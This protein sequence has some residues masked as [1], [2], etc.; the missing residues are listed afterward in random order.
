MIE[1]IG[2]DVIDIDRIK[3]AY[4][5]KSRFVDRILTIGEYEIFHELSGHRQIEFL[6]GRFAAKE[7]FSKA[8]GTGLGKVK[9]SDI[10]VLKNETSGKPY[11]SNSPYSGNCFISITHT[12]TVAVAQVILEKE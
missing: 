12:S 10:E 5:K 3:S 1:G 8:L 4:E 6:A 9:F 7:A 11:V 2:L